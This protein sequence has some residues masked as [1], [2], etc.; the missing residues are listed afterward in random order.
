MRLIRIQTVQGHVVEIDPHHILGLRQLQLDHGEESVTVCEVLVTGGYA[1]ICVFGG[2]DQVKAQLQ[3]I[4]ER[5]LR[6]T[7]LVVPS[8]AVPRA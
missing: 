5:A 7:G 2:I 8:G 1:G 3:A 6:G 4:T